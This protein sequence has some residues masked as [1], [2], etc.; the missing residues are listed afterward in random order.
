MQLVF[1][2]FV[3]LSFY[4][5]YAYLNRSIS[6]RFQFTE[7]ARAA[8]CPFVGTEGMRCFD[9]SP[10][11][12]SGRKSNSN[13]LKLPRGVGMTV[14]R[15]SGRLVAPAVKL[16]YQLE[17]CHTYWT[18]SL[19]GAMF[20]VFNE[21]KI[22]PAN[23]VVASS[24]AASIEVFRNASQLNEAWRRSFAD[25]KVRGGELARPPDLLE[26]NNN[27]FKRDDALALSQRVIGLYT[28]TLNVSTVQLNSFA[29]QA[30]SQLTADS[31]PDVYEDFVDAW[32]THIVTKS[33]VG[34][35]VEQRAIV[36]RCFEA[37]SD[38]T[39]TQCIPFSDRDPN[40]FTC[41]YYAAFTRV[42]S[43]RHLGGD[44]AVDNDKEWRKTLAVGPALLQI[45]EMV[46]WYDFVNDTAV[47][48]N[49]RTIIRY[50]QR[51]VDLVQAEAV[52]QVD[53]N[54]PSCP[55]IIPLR[56]SSID[57]YPAA[58]W[59]QNGITVAGGNGQGS[60]I[61]QL[62]LP[63]GLYVDH[64]Q[65][66]YVADLFNHRIVAW[67]SGATNG[68]VVAGGNGEGSGAHQ[69]SPPVDVIVD[70]RRD[71]LIVCDS[72]NSRVVRW[73]L[74]NGTKGETIISNVFCG[75]LTMDEDGSLYVVDYGNHEVRRYRR[76]ESRGTVVAGGNGR[77][78]RL[79]QLNHPYYV[80]VDRDHTVYV[81]DRGNNRVTKWIEGEKQSIIVA[82]GQ[83]PGNSLTQLFQPMGITVDQLGTLYVADEWNHRVMRW[84]KGATQGSVIVGVNGRGGQSNQLNGPVGLSFDRHG[85]LYVAE[86]GNNR[87]QKFNLESNNN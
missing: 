16:T 25:G 41:G 29:R 80:F 37:L 44:A 42:I 4:V 59:Q 56:A 49:L 65:T 69:L 74:Q 58:R 2:L 76:G 55:P 87:V 28:L 27:Y 11:K 46:P 26:Y 38:P 71:S 7:E 20:D 14:D 32:G 17:G 73:L 52:R 34:G 47:K 81:S 86:S 6:S 79:N 12:P 75:G 68:Q 70:K 30:I 66:V 39:F 22:G 40:N 33:L 5:H 35:M 24:D 60:A 18:D 82:G 84:P 63:Y 19:T 83:G 3:V 78:S 1:R 10:M 50:R 54:L 67:K 53:G 48:H 77:G 62:A 9:G 72:S 43:T 85:N 23:V 31:D 61:N 15:R 21:A 64:N 13:Y 57:I 8:L 51:N 36:K 45:L